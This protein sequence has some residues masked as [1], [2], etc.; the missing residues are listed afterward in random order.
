MLPGIGGFIGTAIVAGSQTYSTPGTYTF[1]VPSYN[2]ITF[3]VYGGGGGGGWYNV[4]AVY[5]GSQGG[6][7]S[8]NIPQGTFEATGGGGGGVSTTTP[9][10]ISGG[11]GTAPSGGTTA[12]GGDAAYG[13]G[14]R[15][16]GTAGGPAGGSGGSGTAVGNPPGGGG[17]GYGG[18]TDKGTQ[19]YAT[20]GGGAGYASYTTSEYVG[21]TLTVIVGAGGTSTFGS[22]I[23]GGDGR[24]VITWS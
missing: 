7:S 23:Y 4:G 9:A 21:T 11:T 24:V 3:E 15:T 8:V 20:G 1:D 13:P 10:P 16:G 17:G 18:V 22:S 19:R 14:N 5:T 12:S 6:T 2:S